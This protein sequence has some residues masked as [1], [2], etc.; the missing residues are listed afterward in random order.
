MDGERLL[1]GSGNEMGLCGLTFVRENSY[2][3]LTFLTM[4]EVLRC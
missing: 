2:L 1:E 4:S 3:K